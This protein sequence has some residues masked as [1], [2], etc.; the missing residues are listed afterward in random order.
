AGEELPSIPFDKSKPVYEKGEKHAEVCPRPDPSCAK[1]YDEPKKPAGFH[2]ACN[3]N[4]WVSADYTLSWFRPWRVNGPPVT[5]GPAAD[6][7][8][9]A[10]GQPGTGTLLG[11]H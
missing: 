5:T 4:W 10:L 3:E 2:R 6:N 11:D 1:G 9:G 8:P 7:R